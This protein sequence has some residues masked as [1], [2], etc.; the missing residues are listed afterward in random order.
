MEAQAISELRNGPNFRN[1][2]VSPTPELLEEQQRVHLATELARRDVNLQNPPQ[3]YLYTRWYV[4]KM[5]QLSITLFFL[6]NKVWLLIIC[7][8]QKIVHLNSNS[9]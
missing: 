6:E 3:M 2:D 4:K 8:K 1:I 9:T 5:Q 7:N